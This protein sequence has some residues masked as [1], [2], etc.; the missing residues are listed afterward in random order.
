MERAM[1]SPDQFERRLR[2]LLQRKPYR[3]VRIVLEGGDTFDID[4]PQFVARDGGAAGY[5]DANQEPWLF[6]YQ[7]TVSITEAPSEV[8]S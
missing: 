2:E 4:D 8:G 6:D 3:P 7:D 1:M 5:I